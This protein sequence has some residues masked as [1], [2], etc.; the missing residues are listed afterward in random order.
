MSKSVSE[1]MQDQL[2]PI[3]N[4]KEQPVQDESDGL[5]FFHTHSL[6]TVLQEVEK[7]YECKIYGVLDIESL[8]NELSYFPNFDKEWDGHIIDA[9][10]IPKQDMLRAMQ[11][12][13][14]NTGG[15]YDSYQDHLDKVEDFLIDLYT[16]GFAD[17]K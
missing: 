7:F 11:Y 1:Q 2:E 6:W 16:G 13:Y 3:Y 9:Y 5:L 15:E 14:D 17:E 12:A 10:K 4:D 8:Q